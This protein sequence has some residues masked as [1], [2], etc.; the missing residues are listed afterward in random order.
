MKGSCQ[1]MLHNITMKNKRYILWYHRT[2]GE[3]MHNYFIIFRFY[4]ISTS[5][6][7]KGCKHGKVDWKVAPLC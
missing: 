5:C 2:I 6:K 7:F 4:M 3:S 1:A